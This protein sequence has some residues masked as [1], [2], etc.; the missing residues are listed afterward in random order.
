MEY[1]AHGFLTATAEPFHQTVIAVFRVR[2]GQVVSCRDYI[3]PLPLLEVFAS[4]GDP[5][6]ADT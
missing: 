2:S 4:L 5:H 1:E 3:N 6:P